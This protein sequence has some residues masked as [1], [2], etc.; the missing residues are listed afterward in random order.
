MRTAATQVGGEG[1]VG[2]AA[3]RQLMQMAEKAHRTGAYKTVAQAFV[4]MMED[5][6]N[7]EL[8]SAAVLRTRARATSRHPG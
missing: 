2:D 6:N 7:K 3:Y 4:A 5:G 1:D 8:A